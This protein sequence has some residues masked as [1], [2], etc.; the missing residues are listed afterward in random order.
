MKALSPAQIPASPQPNTSDSQTSGRNPAS[1]LT[2]VAVRMNA[3]S[4]APIKTPSRAKTIPANSRWAT[5]NHHGTP[6]ASSTA[7]SPVN[8]DKHRRTSR[9]NCRGDHRGEAEKAVTRQA[10]CLAWLGSPAP[11][12]APTRD[13]AAMASESSTSARKLPQP[14][15]TGERPEPLHRIAPPPPQRTEAGL[16]RHGAHHQ[17]GP[18]PPACAARRNQLRTDVFGQQMPGRTTAPRATAP[19]G[20]PPPS[21]PAPNAEI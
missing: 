8:A 18:S 12:A 5:R 20:W 7:R 1:A 16:K 13:W 14:Q 11:R 17:I 4:P 2:T 9:Q 10:T 15:T 3:A 19:P 21:Q 6:I